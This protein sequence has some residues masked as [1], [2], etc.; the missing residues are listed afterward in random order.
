MKRP[1]GVTASAIVAIIGS[2]FALLVA[3]MS[4][5]SL[6]ITTPQPRPPNVAQFVIPG[7]AMSAALGVI[8]IWTASGLFSLRPR[9]RTSVLVFAGF[10]AGLS[11]LGLLVTLTV[12][13][14][15]DITAGTQRNFR[16]GMAVIYGIPLLISIWWLIQFNRSSTKAAFA[17]SIDEPA[18]PR[19]ISITVIAWTSILGG[20][21]CLGP[22]FAGM[23]AFLFG[24][25]FHGWIAS[26]F[27]AFLA[28]LSFYIGKGLL[29]LREEARVLAIGWFVFTLVH[30][31]AI[32]LVPT[33]RHRMFDLQKTLDQNPPTP[34]VVDL[35]L[36][37]NV[38]LVASTIL[39]LAAIWFL[40]RNRAAFV[41]TF[42]D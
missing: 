8:G 22:L 35:D 17:S 34:M 32:T 18:S 42:A 13:I 20:A 12:P 33:L 25:V 10:L 4:I 38:V 9:A 6:F 1:V 16:Q 28:A 3:A 15:P 19:P 37:T 23:P 26:I 2:V 39:G 14:P 27:Y 36:V 41:H 21:G 40:I 30:A 11:I 24:L 5:A 31:S 7:A 29:D